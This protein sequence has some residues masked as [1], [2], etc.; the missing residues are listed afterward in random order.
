[1]VRIINLFYGVTISTDIK[2]LDGDEGENVE[3]E[4]IQDE[5]ADG[6]DVS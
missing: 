3:E 4:E 5:I 6:E 2:K 1:M